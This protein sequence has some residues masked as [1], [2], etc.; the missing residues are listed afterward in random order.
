MGQ[1]LSRRSLSSGS[2]SI[3]QIFPSAP[4][5]YLA[6]VYSLAGKIQLSAHSEGTVGAGDVSVS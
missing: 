4:R 1:R 6:G 2:I 5:S 3:R